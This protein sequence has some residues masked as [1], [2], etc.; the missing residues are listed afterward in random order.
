MHAS[1]YDGLTSR[2]HPVTLALVDRRWHVDGEAVSRSEHAD[3]VQISNALGS[4]PRF[5]RFA[6]GAVCE[7]DDTA[8]LAELLSSGH[9][10]DDRI[11]RSIVDTKLIA[12]IL[13]GF[14]VLLLV[15]YRYGVPAAAN[16][17]ADRAP[18]VATRHLGATTLKTLDAMVFA[19]TQVDFERQASLQSAF[20]RLTMPGGRKPA[21]T[22]LFRRSDAI[23][24]NAMT[25][26][27]GTIVV[28]DGLVA[29]AR[30]D[31][32]ILGVLAHEAGHASRRHAL[33]M[34]LESSALS[35]LLSWYVGDVNTVAVTAPASLLNAK[36]S[37]DFE[38]EADDYAMTVM[39]LNG[40]PP[41]ALADILERMNRA[42]EGRSGPA[43]LSTHP[44]T[45][46]R[47]AQFRR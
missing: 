1:Y 40:I 26:P 37:R 21:S 5:V 30:S 20:A 36:Y 14:I 33:R 44:A 23:G 12:G 19:P 29:M 41:G 24:A 25:L 22:V 16:A 27:D 28:T 43:Y 11:G 6:D 34:M 13:A 4:T 39:R 46:E 42:H 38:R 17:A 31:Q 47:L 3:S 18:E 45:A 32:E 7:V 10:A 9:I 8:A 2:R 35:A 15:T